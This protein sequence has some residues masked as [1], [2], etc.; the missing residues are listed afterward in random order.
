MDQ[1]PNQNSQVIIVNFK[2]MKSKGALLSD[3]VLSLSVEDVAGPPAVGLLFLLP[4]SSG[5]V[6][7]AS[8]LKYMALPVDHTGD[9]ALEEAVLRQRRNRAASVQ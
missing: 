3:D 9:E 5:L 7:M 2:S 1:Q 6:F 4:S 8:S